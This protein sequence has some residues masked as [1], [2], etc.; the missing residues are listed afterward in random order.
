ME[1]KETLKL[2]RIGFILLCISTS[3]SPAKLCCCCC[4][5][6]R[7]QVFHVIIISSLSSIN[8]TNSKGIHPSAFPFRICSVH[9]SSDAKGECDVSL[10]PFPLQMN[11]IYQIPA[12]DFQ[13]CVPMHFLSYQSFIRFMEAGDNN[14]VYLSVFVVSL[15]FIQIH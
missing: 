3:G 10:M 5:C 13:S 12:L 11:Y 9:F 8:H 7:L 4:G 15:H 14:Y 6:N 2:K 1:G